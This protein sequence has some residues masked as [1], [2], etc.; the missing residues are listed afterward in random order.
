MLQLHQDRC[1]TGRVSCSAYPACHLL[2]RIVPLFLIRVAKHGCIPL[3]QRYGSIA[4]LHPYKEGLQDTRGH[5]KTCG[6]RWRSRRPWCMKNKLWGCERRRKLS[7]NEP[8]IRT[9]RWISAGTRK[10]MLSSSMLWLHF[11]RGPSGLWTCRQLEILTSISSVWISLSR[12]QRLICA[13]AVLAE[14]I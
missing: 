4:D 14:L 12:D 7:L 8:T 2:C 1:E 6:N 5:Y 3:R 10:R 11:L 13:A 9:G